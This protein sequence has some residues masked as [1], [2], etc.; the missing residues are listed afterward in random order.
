VPKDQGGSTLSRRAFVGKVAAGAAVTVAVSGL[1]RA[2][3]STPRASAAAADV[4]APAAA[5]ESAPAVTASAPP[6]WQML[7]PLALGSTLAGGWK[8]A[9][10]SDIEHGSCV[11]TLANERGR[12]HRIHLC[13]NDGRPQGVVH[14]EALDLLVMNGGQGDQ[15]TEEG[16]AQ[17]VAEVAHAL[18]ANEGRHAPLVTSLLPQAERAE[19]FA[20]SAVLR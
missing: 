15:P 1:Q 3:A 11:L 14:T 8:V 13:R 2:Q 12:T 10:L 20:T 18:A 19:R 9:G 6:P 17:A 7:R 5:G 16:L 4:T